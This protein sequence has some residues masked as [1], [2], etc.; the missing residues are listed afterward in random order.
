MKGIHAPFTDSLEHTTIHYN[1]YKKAWQLE[2]Y[3]VIRLLLLGGYNQRGFIQALYK[4]YYV[5]CWFDYTD[6]FFFCISKRESVEHNS[7]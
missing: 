7:Y 2:T 3:L 1:T 5:E 4:A 6:S